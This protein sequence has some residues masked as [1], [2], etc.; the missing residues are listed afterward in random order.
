MNIFDFFSEFRIF[1]R[2]FQLRGVTFTCKELWKWLI[3]SKEQV[4]T[5]GEV[6]GNILQADIPGRGCGFVIY[7]RN[8]Y[9]N[10]TK[11]CD[12]RPSSKLARHAATLAQ[13]LL[14]FKDPRASLTSYFKEGATL[15]RPWFSLHP[16]RNISIFQSFFRFLELRCTISELQKRPHRVRKLLLI[17]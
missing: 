1:C 3:T 11:Q 17:V 2:F 9:Q 12:A 10:F 5:I 14:M 16:P 13:P 4:A 15:A 7:F 8:I 6:I